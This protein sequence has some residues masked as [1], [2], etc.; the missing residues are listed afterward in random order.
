MEPGSRTTSLLRFVIP[1]SDTHA[2]MRRI[3][4]MPIILIRR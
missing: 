4:L 3:P 2:S 1:S